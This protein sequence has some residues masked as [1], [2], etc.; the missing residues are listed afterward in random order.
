[1]SVLNLY[2]N[3]RPYQ[4]KWKSEQLI[5]IEKGKLAINNENKLLP[6]LRYV[7]DHQ[8]QKDCR[9]HKMFHFL[10]KSNRMDIIVEDPELNEEVGYSIS[11]KN[12]VDYIIA[13]NAISAQL[14]IA[15]EHLKSTTPAMDCARNQSD[16]VGEVQKKEGGRKTKKMRKSKRKTKRRKT[17]R[18]KTKRRTNNLY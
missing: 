15:D 10:D 5:T 8:I 3:L 18:R 6:I 11:F 9:K 14:G 4:G 7:T 1:M 13:K 17:K 12:E 2:V 16:D